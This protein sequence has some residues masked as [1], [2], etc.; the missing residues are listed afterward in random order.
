MKKSAWLTYFFT[1]LVVTSMIFIATSCA[2]IVPPTGGPR[3][4]LPPYLIATKPQDSAL[5]IK[6]KE[7][8]LA[9]NEYVNTTDIFNNFVI[10]PAIKNTPQIDYK[11][12]VV[13]IKITDT[14]ADNTTYSLQFGN[15]IR[16]VNE[17]NVAK[18]LT[19][20]FSTGQQIDTGS[21]FGKVQMA[22][23][24]LIDSTLIVGLYPVENDS[25][26]FKSNPP[27]IAK[28]NGQGRFAFHFLP[29]KKFNAYV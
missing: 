9:F 20:V 22:E 16:D 15:A 12:N 24:G 14:L 27:F 21:F 1:C 29:N 7:I 28:I 17:N 6:P 2:N 23:T 19:Y 4:S 3:D 26:V 10:N 13:R 8:M 25:A 5:G 11:L 18:N